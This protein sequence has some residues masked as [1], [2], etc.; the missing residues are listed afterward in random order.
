[1]LKTTRAENIK[2]RIDK[3]IAA[4]VTEVERSTDS[5]TLDEIRCPGCR[6]P[7]KKSLNQELGIQL[8]EC[9]SCGISWFDA[10]ELAKL[11]LE[12][13]SR[14]QT[15]ELNSMRERL[16]TMDEAERNAYEQRIANLVDL[17]TPMEQA[18]REATIELNA[19]S[20]GIS[21]GRQR[22]PTFSPG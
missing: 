10:G 3:D 5:D 17:G 11:Q 6:V 13:E 21:C 20:P 12:F 2:R 19:I 1:M 4:L 8:D 22:S 7:M 16:A 9:K 14:S 18:I 15:V